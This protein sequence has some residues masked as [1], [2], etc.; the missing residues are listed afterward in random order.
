MTGAQK[1]VVVAIAP[2][3]RGFGFAIFATPL[4]VLDWGVKEVRWD[5]NRRSRVRIERMLKDVRP[6]AVI[7]ENWAHVSCRRSARVRDLLTEVVVLAH[8]RGAT[9]H[10][11]S[12]R[13]VRQLFGEAGKSKDAVAAVL[14]ARLP[15]LKPWLP[16]KRRIW[17]SEHY[18]MAIFEAAALAVT[19]CETQRIAGA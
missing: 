8:K 3:S 6:T 2:T 10:T 15:A 1:Q 9:A 16:P 7:I 18:S 5:K 4:R 12:R 11:Y 19:H 14:V 17:E 13:Q